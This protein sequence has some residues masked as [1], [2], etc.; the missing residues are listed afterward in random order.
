MQTAIFRWLSESEVGDRNTQ[1][2]ADWEG[3]IIVAAVSSNLSRIQQVFDAADKTGR[4]VVLTG[5][6]I[7]NIV[8]SNSSQEIV[9]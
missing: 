7:E 8:H 1:T 6:D 5:F 4:R 2:I 3:R 9:F